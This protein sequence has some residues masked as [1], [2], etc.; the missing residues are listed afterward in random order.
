MLLENTNPAICIPPYGVQYLKHNLKSTRAVTRAPWPPSEIIFYLI[1]ILTLLR[2]KWMYDCHLF[3][4][5]LLRLDKACLNLNFKDLWMYV[6]ESQMSM[7]WW[8]MWTG[9]VYLKKEA[10]SRIFIFQEFRKGK[11]TGVAALS[12][13]HAWWHLL[14]I[15]LLI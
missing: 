11:S 3:V 6:T 2:Y 4:V 12:Q 15:H 1:L 10:R 7:E 13:L 14:G 9:E 5:L 8:I